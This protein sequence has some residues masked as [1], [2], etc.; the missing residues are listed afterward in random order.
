[1]LVQTQS[2]IYSV[3]LRLIPPVALPPQLVEQLPEP[4]AWSRLSHR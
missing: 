2:T 1:L 4:Q 3:S